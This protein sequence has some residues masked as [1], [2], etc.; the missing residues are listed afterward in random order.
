MQR[1]IHR[2][3]L[4]AK[5]M[6]PT[7]SV[8][9]VL[10]L[11]RVLARPD[12]LIPSWPTADEFRKMIRHLKGISKLVS[13]SEGLDLVL[14]K[15]TPG[16]YSAITFDDGYSDNFEIASKVLAQEG[17]RATF[18]V[19]TDYVEGSMMFNDLIRESIRVSNQESIKV[20]QLGQTLLPIRSIS[21]K[22]QTIR[23]INQWLK[24]TH[25]NQ[26]DIEAQKI[27]RQLGFNVSGNMMMTNAQL[28][29]LANAGFEIGS[30][31]NRHLIA[32]TVSH[33]EFASDVTLSK[34]RLESAIQKNVDLF[35]FPNGKAQ[36]DFNASYSQVIKDCGFKAA[37]SSEQKII[38]PESD[39]FALPRFTPW[40]RSDFV[41]T[42]QIATALNSR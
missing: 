38:F 1:I 23:S 34:V 19:A 27:A 40:S 10:T 16:F 12:P 36:K 18:F 22:L 13:L 32:T 29:L 26:R 7:V 17:A 41:R 31:T 30:H 2:L 24:Y 5:G 14:N 25:P 33:D 42:L 9:D 28:I 3:I 6:N 4:R 35:A 39:R 21:E 15:Q 8:L 37:F 20:D 11:H